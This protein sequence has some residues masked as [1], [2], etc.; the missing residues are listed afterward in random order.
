[1]TCSCVTFTLESESY[2][3]Y[4]KK[5][6]QLGENETLNKD[7][8]IYDWWS[9]DFTTYDADL[10]TR[11]VVLKGIEFLCEENLCSYFPW[12]FPVCFTAEFNQQFIDMHCMMDNHEEVTVS[13]LSD[14]LD[15]VY[16]IKNF[17]HKSIQVPNALEWQLTLE[18]VRDS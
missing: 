3:V 14:D 4:L 15:A 1:M 18:K 11:P 7:V 16:I 6:L 13:G 2:L 17:S 10:V 5:P 12:C 8:I 9:G